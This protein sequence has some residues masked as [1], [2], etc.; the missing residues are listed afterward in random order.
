M[1]SEIPPAR[2]GDEW[3]SVDGTLSHRE[4]KPLGERGDDGKA[5]FGR[6]VFECLLTHELGVNRERTRAEAVLDVLCGQLARRQH[7]ITTEERHIDTGR[8]V[9]H[10]VQEKFEPFADFQPTEEHNLRRGVIV[11]LGRGTIGSGKG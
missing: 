1:I 8:Q 3:E 7:G 9:A 4:S 10:G 5:V 2:G 6:E 11:G